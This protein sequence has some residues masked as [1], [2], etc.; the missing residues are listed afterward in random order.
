M[1]FIDQLTSLLSKNSNIENASNMRKYMRGKFI[2][3]G[4]KTTERRNI[5]KQV[6]VDNKEELSRNVREL[7]LQ[8]YNLPQRELHLC[9]TELFEKLLK[10]K[11]IKEDILLIE[12]LITTN[13]WWDTVDFISKQVLGNYLTMY[14]VEIETVISKFSS[15]NNIWLNRSTI[16]FQLGYKDNTKEELLFKQC[17]IHKHSNE[18]FI[19]KAIGWALREYGKTNPKSVI[20]FVNS[21]SLKPLSH[22]EAIRN[23]V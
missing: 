6:I 18:F 21:T 20:N 14:P 15:A 16:I 2:Y 23:I 3:Y 10:K 1:S 7:V 12:Q 17:N 13:S 19:Q 9:A 4:V 8:L 22:R 11:F 5:L